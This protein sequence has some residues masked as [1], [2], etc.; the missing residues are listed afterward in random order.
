MSEAK[1]MKNREHT[2]TPG[3]KSHKH[4]TNK[5]ALA[6]LIFLIILLSIKPL[7]SQ[8]GDPVDSWVVVID[9]GHGGKD[10]GAVSR[11]IHESDI[12]L[13]IALKLGTYI[14]M[15]D[16]VKV[17]YT[18]SSDISVDLDKRPKFANDNN[19][20][21]FISIHAN[22]GE[23]SKIK[24]TETFVMG[25]SK[26]DQNL[27]V[28]MKEN[29]VI[30][31]EKDYTTRYQGFD[32]GSPESYIILSVMQKEYSAQ[33]LNFAGM[34]QDQ[35]RIKAGRTDRSVKQDV[36]LVLWGTTMPSILVE[37][38]FI[39]NPDEVKFLS[40]SQ[41][42]DLIASAIFRAFR[43]YKNTIDKKSSFTILQNDTGGE[44]IFMV[45]IA[46]SSTSKD[47]IPDNFK[48][49]ADLTEIN[50]G[51]KFKYATGKFNNYDQAVEHRKK[52]SNIFPDAFVVA[53]KD[54]KIVPLQEAMEK[55]MQ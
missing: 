42:Q 51:D 52:L 45:Q 48:G 39:T 43:D 6:V 25:P 16:N 1:L 37:T 22:W 36:F 28:A 41:G 17:L 3:I 32:P 26:N 7:I 21:V 8:T 46:T 23:S 50:E 33:S 44:I 31:L 29:S 12:T 19:A 30:T 55:T 5:S 2:M 9:P 34:V 35:F 18:R 27:K 11:N 24:G 54:N 15:L 47:L 20:S 40:S 49:V 13:A 10:P 4:Y 53:V 38:G 14:A